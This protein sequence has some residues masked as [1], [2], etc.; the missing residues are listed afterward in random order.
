MVIQF[1][2][3][4][5]LGLIIYM[6]KETYEDGKASKLSLTVL[7][8]KLSDYENSNTTD[9]TVFN[10]DIKDLR[11]V[12]KDLDKRTTILEFKSVNK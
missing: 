2:Q 12:T 5:A 1:I 6:A 7:T 8:Q 4:A 3:L 9:H 11:I 10:S